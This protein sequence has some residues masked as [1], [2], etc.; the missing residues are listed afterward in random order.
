M[1]LRIL[2]D[3]AA[4]GSMES[5]GQEA[6][7]KP[8]PTLFAVALAL[9]AP[10]AAGADLAPWDQARATA[11]A[12]ELVPAATELYDAFYKQ[13]QPPSTPRSARDYERLRRDIRLIRQGARGLAAD[14]E[15]GEGRE[16]TLDA[17]RSLVSRVRWARE[18]ARSVFT[19]KDVEERAAAF[20]RILGDLA[21]FYDPEAPDLR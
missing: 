5:L 18:R 15:H 8:A 16:Q 12:R 21:P 11:L 2:A 3:P 13:P 17:Y 14:L 7:L 9:L 4:L 19:T 20:G 10:G 6:P 1:A